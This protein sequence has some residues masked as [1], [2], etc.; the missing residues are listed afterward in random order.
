MAPLTSYGGNLIATL[1]FF[2]EG[3]KYYKV[4]EKVDLAG[5]EPGDVAA[6]GFPAQLVLLKTVAHS[7]KILHD[8]AHR[9]QRPQAEQRHDQAHRAGVHRPNSSTSTAPTSSATRRR[10]R[11]SS[12]R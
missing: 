2:R 1:D 5:L 6:L 8:L 7:L 10:R 3:A 4:T 12:A 11:R 9:A